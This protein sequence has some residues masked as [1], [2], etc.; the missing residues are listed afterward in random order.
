MFLLFFFL[1]VC[2]FCFIL[3]YID[4]FICLFVFCGRLWAL[5]WRSILIRLIKEEKPRVEVFYN[6][7]PVLHDN[8][9]EKKSG[10]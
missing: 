1:F 4:F 7:V 10:L 5:L 8:L 3:V 2:L 6:K 9:V